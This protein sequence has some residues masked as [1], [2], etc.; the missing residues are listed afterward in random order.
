[1]NFKDK[2]I[3][4]TGAGS[5]MGRELTKQLVQKGAHVAAID[6]H[7]KALMETVVMA[8]G[9]VSSHLVD[10]TDQLKVNALPEQILQVHGKMD[11]LINN[12]GIIQPFSDVRELDDRVIHKVMDI[13]FFG[14]VNMTKAFLLYLLNR[15]EAFLA[16]TSSMGGFIPFPG[17]T[18]YSASKAAVKVFTEGLYAELKNTKVRVSVIFPGAVHTNIM[19]NSGVKME[20]IGQS[21]HSENNIL[22]A[23]KAAE[24][25]IAGL[26]KEK[27]RIV[28]GKDAR[29]L[30][31]FYRFSPKMAIDFITKQ[32][33]KRG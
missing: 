19:E 5:G 12:A 27:F 33:K 31:I 22:T 15:P 18:V 6:I 4:I 29:F 26:E 17:Q 11:G 21:Q 1:M 7:E 8:G 32:M 16:N 23:S 13:N 14:M 28:V 30:D 9:K 25:I 10:I 20:S 24:I 3:V 2:V